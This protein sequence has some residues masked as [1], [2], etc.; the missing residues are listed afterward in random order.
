MH[1][2]Q[3][4]E[5]SI[6]STRQK[7]IARFRD[8]VR[9]RLRRCFKGETTSSGS[10]TFCFAHFN[11]TNFLEVSL[12]AVRQ[13][14]RDER[15]IVADASSV[16]SEFR[17][18]KS[19][20]S[21]YG[22]ELHPLLNFHRHTGLLNYM[23]RKATTP[24]VVFLDQDCVLLD[25]LD[26]LLEAVARG[27]TLIGPSDEMR[28]TH[29]N[30]CSVYPNVANRCFRIA[31]E[32]IHASLM[33]VNTPRVRAWAKHRPFHWRDEWGAHPLER[34]YGVTQ[35]VRQNQPDAVMTLDSEHTGYGLGQ[36]Y[37]FNGSPIAYHQWYSGQV[38]GQSGKLDGTFDADWLRAE[39]KRFLRD[40][41]D[42]RV[43]F[44]L[45]QGPRVNS[46]SV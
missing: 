6:L 11:A 7:K 34:Y 14:Y 20:C 35:L 13:R 42:N 40:Y 22:A 25:R 26:A 37:T 16:W 31:P 46:P 4:S 36:V 43:D 30:L 44:K 24:V 28:L 33:V 10:V 12:D 39:T 38:Y 1:S 32:F 3:P 29:Q 17:A 2:A 23:F 45:T 9:F 15:I 41:W 18:A 19:V 8:V 5:D 21:Q 27:T